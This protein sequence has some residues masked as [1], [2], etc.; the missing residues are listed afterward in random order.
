MK[1]KTAKKKPMDT[2]LKNFLISTGVLVLATVIILF[3]I[4]YLISPH[5]KFEVNDCLL[6]RMGETKIVTEV[7]PHIGEYNLY[8]ARYVSNP[9]TD[10]FYTE[11]VFD[12]DHRPV[13]KP[14]EFVDKNYIKIPC[15]R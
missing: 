15:V 2:D 13:D 14:I 7:Y 8:S 12:W 11:K 4:N 9:F 5:P 10:G 6:N 3:S 1:K